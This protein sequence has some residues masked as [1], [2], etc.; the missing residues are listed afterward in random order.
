MISIFLLW[1]Q[2]SL[3]KNILLVKRLLI[4]GRPPFFPPYVFG[5]T[6]CVIFQARRNLTVIEKFLSSERIR[7][8]YNSQFFFIINYLFLFLRF[9]DCDAILDFS[10]HLA[11]SKSAPEFLGGGLKIWKRGI[12]FCHLKEFKI[13]NLKFFN[14]LNFFWSFF[15]KIKI[16]T[17]QRK[18]EIQRRECSTRFEEIFRQCVFYHE[19]IFVCE[20]FGII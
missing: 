18:I 17:P 9:V 11:F 8:I 10:T 16:D 3:E 14:F 5:Q 12:N 19:G 20:K 1:F 7:N 4:L 2:F 6:F 13:T 15:R